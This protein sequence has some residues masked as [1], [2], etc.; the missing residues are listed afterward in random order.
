MAAL[1]SLDSGNEQLREDSS[2]Q[3][4]GTLALAA[5]IAHCCPHVSG[6]RLT[7]PTPGP[8]QGQTVCLHRNLSSCHHINPAV[9]FLFLPSLPHFYLNT[10]IQS[11]PFGTRNPLFSEAIYLN[12]RHKDM[13]RDSSPP[14]LGVHLGLCNC[15]TC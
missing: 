15:P 9:S 7:A 8:R 2:S 4:Q 6:A 14:F 12:S 1:T 3:W 10:G 13:H 11:P 5:C